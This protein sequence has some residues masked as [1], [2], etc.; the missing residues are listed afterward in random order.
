MYSVILIP[1]VAK[2]LGLL[3]IVNDTNSL[4]VARPNNIS[5]LYGK[6]NRKLYGI[7][8]ANIEDKKEDQKY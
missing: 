8:S 3:R 2:W 7:C 1:L 6:K 5:K 4:Y